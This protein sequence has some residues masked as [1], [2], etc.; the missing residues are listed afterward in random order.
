M[1]K[2]KH[3]LIDADDTIFDYGK[4]ETYALE[5][6]FSPFY[7][8]DQL[9]EVFKSYRKINSNYWNLFEQKMISLENL[10]TRRFKDLLDEHPLSYPD[11]NFESLAKLY[12]EHLGRTDFLF[13]NAMETL[14]KLSSSFSL[15]MVTNGISSVQRSRFSKSGILK[16]FRNIFISEELGYSK[17][18]P[19]FFDH[20]FSTI[21]KKPAQ[22]LNKADFCIIGDSLNS[23]IQGGINSGIDTILFD[24]TGKN[25]NSKKVEII[26]PS[27][28]VY[29]Y[30]SLLE[31]LIQ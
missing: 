27:Y 22:K 9:Q 16:Y 14:E 2:Y 17:P 26:K 23:D 8:Q 11:L 20:V 29:D 6:T 5:K 13:D 30:N 10:K 24:Y 21:I 28:I 3:L 19:L 18:D 25:R 31:F 7:H 1:V 12:I 15:H 4:A